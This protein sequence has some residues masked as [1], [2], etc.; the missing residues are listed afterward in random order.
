MSH[1]L[2]SGEIKKHMENEEDW[3]LKVD[4]DEGEIEET[5]K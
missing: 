3:G 1:D 5:N 4:P 2:G